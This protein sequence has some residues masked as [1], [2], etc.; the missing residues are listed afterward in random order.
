[1]VGIGGESFKH[2]RYRGR[3]N[4]FYGRYK[5]QVMVGIGGNPLLRTPEARKN[6]RYREQVAK[7]V[8]GIGGESS[9]KR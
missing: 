5:G 1:V 8:V 2:S 7:K 4:G 9:K 6:G 3:A